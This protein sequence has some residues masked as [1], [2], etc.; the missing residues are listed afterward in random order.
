LIELP[1]ATVQSTGA[2]LEREDDLAV[3][4]RAL[5]DAA[6]GDGSMLLIE[7]PPG[8]GK[9]SL[10]G[11]LRRRARAR[12]LTVLTA[13]GGELERGVRFGVVRQLLDVPVG[14]ARGGRRE[15]L[16]AG[17]A[18]LAEPVFDPAS[19]LER[20]TDDIAHG[21]LHGLYW[22]V[23]NLAEHRPLVLS[24]DDVHWADEPSIR[25]LIHLAY[26]LTGMPVLVVLACRSGSEQRR[27]ELR[28]LLLEAQGPVIRPRPL[29][30]DSVER[31]VSATLGADAATLAAAC[32]EAT[33]GNPFLLS[34]LLGEIRRDAR[35]ATEIEPDVVRRLGP[36]RIAAALLLRVG[37]LD[38]A[39]PALT[40]AVAVL[41]PQARLTTCAQLAELD[42]RRAR[43]LADELAS[44]AVLER[45]EP[46]RFVHPIVRTA[47]YDD[48][49]AGRRADLHARAA[50]LLADQQADPEQVALHLMATEPAGEP[51]VVAALRDAA[52]QAL[53]SGAPDTAAALLRRALAEPPDAGTGPL[54]HFELGT[55]EH[56][57]GLLTARDHLLEAGRA[58]TDPVI[59]ARAL[60]TLAVDTQPEPARQREQLPLYEQA[61][62][63]VHE[64]DRQL[65][66]Q[67]HGVRLGAL[68]FNLDLP[69]RFEE[70]AETYR[71][72]PGDTPE[73]C[74]LLSFAARKLMAGGENMY[75]VAALAERAAAHPAIQ[76]HG[77]NFWRLN[78]T[79]CLIEAE[80]FDIAEQMQT[81]A[82]REAERAGSALGIAGVS[83]QRALVRYARGD[84][85]GAESDGRAALDSVPSNTLVRVV[86][87]TPSLI[88]ALTDAGR[89]DEADAVLATHG[90]DRALPPILSMGLILLARARLRAATGN[91]EAARTDLEELLRRITA[92]RGL[93]PLI[94]FEAP[95]ALVPVRQA[96]GDLGGARELADTTLR[97]A[98]RV[99]SRRATGAAL[100]VSGLV[101]S[102]EEGL[103]LLRDAADTLRA[104]PALLWRAEALIDLGAALRRHGQRTD[105]CDVL[106]EGMDLAHRCGAVP[107]ADRAA[108]ELRAAG[109]R[110]RRRVTTGAD[111]LTARERRVAELAATGMTNKEIAQSLFVTLRTVEMHLSN[112]YGK[113][114]IPSRQD[115]RTAF[116]GADRGETLRSALR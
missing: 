22:L 108:G 17:A 44:L 60:I 40:R 67:L 54:V 83:W 71:D 70:E 56:T 76:T 98:L 7:G 116:A 81:R 97:A 79:F 69:V 20:D 39:S 47:I 101:R 5:A 110:P 107:L 38:P 103:E 41:G 12:E 74:L 53:A 9:T 63:D 62:R 104:S 23:A 6:A 85:R 51:D 65:A 58:A 14:S 27:P 95:L 84:L 102:G 87:R 26:R 57:L 78:T 66:L 55:A 10:L 106:R 52:R 1:Q 43:E 29:R 64:L 11:E 94:T 48:I 3:I 96:L 88:Q 91:L 105:A 4:D 86:G 50:H 100:R 72:L 36:E 31:L 15:E 46:L 49:P 109:A 34:E 93:S 75:T 68:L 77:I 13:R 73:E 32:H 61:A 45:A 82:L 2:L 37:Q 19:L 90:L 80:C 28:P 89:Y 59:R 92:F 112:V 24:V 25:F 114:G 18:S 16:L 42:V 111:A 99:S 35:P 115:L 8:I 21:T 113:L 30:K 33:G